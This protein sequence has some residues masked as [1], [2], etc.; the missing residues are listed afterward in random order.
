MSPNIFMIAGMPRCGS[1]WHSN[2]LTWG[3]SFCFHDGFYGLESAGEFPDRLHSFNAQNVGNSD[4]ANVLFWERIVEWFPNAKWVVIRRSW[5]DTIDSCRKAYPR[6]NLLGLVQFRQRLTA[7]IDELQPKIID[8]DSISPDT[9]FDVAQFL[10]VD[11]GPR[12]RVE[13]LC[14]MNVQLESDYLRNAIEQLTA[15]RNETVLA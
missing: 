13:Q 2:L 15:A 7:L 1:A 6:S 11:I 3:D 5:E 14:R 8:F 9:A 12:K 4:P 10:D